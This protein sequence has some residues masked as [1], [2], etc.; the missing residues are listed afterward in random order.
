MVEKTVTVTA[1]EGLHA[2]PAGAI[3]KI[4]KDSGCCVSLSTASRTV[5]GDSM[6]GI[7]SLGLKCGT[8]VR[9]SV[10]G[11]G[12]EAVMDSILGQL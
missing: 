7:L 2:R 1:P 6:L 3:V 4:V 12:E 5:R 9:I 10:E 11:A 8:D